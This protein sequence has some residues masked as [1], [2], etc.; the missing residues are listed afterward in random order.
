MKRIVLCP[1]AQRD[2]DFSC[3]LRAKAMLERVGCQ[4]TVSPLYGDEGGPFP[5]VPLG[6]ALEG[7]ELLVTLGGDGTILRIAPIIMEHMV[8]LVGVNL[9]HKGFLAELDGESIELLLQAAEGRFE[10][11]PRMMLDV[12]IRRGGETV[13]SDTG[14]NEAVVSAVVQNIRLAALGDGQQILDFSGDGIIV[15]SP[16]GSTA[17]SMSAGGPLVEPGA[18][19]IILTPI[20]A[21]ML[22]A[23]SFVLTPERVVTV[24]PSDLGPERRGILSVDGRGMTDLQCGDQIIVKRSAHKLLMADLGTKSFYETAFE[25]LGGRT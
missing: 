23:R 4:V 5:P 9:G 3:T 2:E 20:C 13:F 24:I 10:L 15:S 22:A 11:V 7:A 6:E 21:H 12:E 16:T 1:N 25:K 8:P 14:L 19:T 17:Y 18:E